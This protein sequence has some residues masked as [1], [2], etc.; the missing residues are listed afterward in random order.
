MKYEIE[1]P[2]KL[3]K[4]AE[5]MIENGISNSLNALIIQSLNNLIMQNHNWL[6][7][8]NEYIKILNIKV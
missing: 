2:N 5:F 8:Y 1:I 3:S 6:R 7:D 4:I